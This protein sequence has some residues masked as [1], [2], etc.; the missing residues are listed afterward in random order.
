MLPFIQLTIDWSDWAR[1]LRRDQANHHVGPVTMVKLGG[2]DNGRT[3]FRHMN[4]GK[5]T[6]DNISWLQ[7]S[8]SS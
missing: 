6:H 3:S 7:R 2:E 8:S 4:A 1:S 5:R